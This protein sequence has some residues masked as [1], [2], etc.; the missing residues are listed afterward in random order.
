MFRLMR[1]RRGYSF[2]WWAMFFT[3]VF[4]PILN[5]AIGVGRYAIAAAEVQEAAD[6]AALAAVRDVDIRYF[7]HSGVIRFS[8]VV[9]GRA[10]Y[11]ANLNT[12]YLASQK[13]QVHV[14][15]IQA[16]NASQTVRVQCAADITPLFPPI[17]PNM[18]VTR[19]GIAQVKM[20]IS[21]QR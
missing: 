18:V 15:S 21:P 16:D 7:E 20:R 17:V 2:T 4:L 3:F 12:D 9:Y 19:T 6:L 5:L 8:G 11:Y 13:I 1:E 10:S 14:V